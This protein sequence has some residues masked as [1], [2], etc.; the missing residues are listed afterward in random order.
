[1][2]DHFCPPSDKISTLKG[3]NSPLPHPTTHTLHPT[4][5]GSKSFLLDFRVGVFSD[6]LGLEESKQEVTK[7]V[8]HVQI[9]G[10]IPS[11]SSHLKH[12]SFA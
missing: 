2:S 12:F 8:Y 10:S 5:L 6:G 11:I 3:K 7:V 1:M 4:H 9:A